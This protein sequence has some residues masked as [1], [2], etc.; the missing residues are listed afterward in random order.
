MLFQLDRV[1]VT[2]ASIDAEGVAPPC[3]VFLDI[4]F[5]QLGDACTPWEP[6][7]RNGA[8]ITQTTEGL[9][10]R[11]SAQANSYGRCHSLYPVP[12]TENGV[13]AE[14]QQ[15]LPV[16]YTVL[17]LGATID[18]QILAGGGLLRL[19]NNLGDI[20]YTDMPE[21]A[22]SPTEMRWWRLRRTT[23][24]VVTAEYSSDAKDWK[25]LG[26]HTDTSVDAYPFVTGGTVGER[27]VATDTAIYRRLIMCN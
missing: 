19:T 2:D 12:I 17:S 14:V 20:I 5:D 4:K 26:V 1:E 21:P 11:P 15:I 13:M 9:T 27:T 18:L 8:V 24:S 6:D 16:G 10:I 25:R 23:T 7:I 3:A 22:Y